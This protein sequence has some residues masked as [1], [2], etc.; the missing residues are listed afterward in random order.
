MEKD[1]PL[2]MRLFEENPYAFEGTRWLNETFPDN[3]IPPAF[4]GHNLVS[5]II[6]SVN[7]PELAQVVYT[8]LNRFH[9]KHSDTKASFSLT[10]PKAIFWQATEEDTYHAR[11]KVLSQA[12]FKS[13]LLTLIEIIK[14]VTMRHLNDTDK[15]NEVDIPQFTMQLQGRIIINIGIGRG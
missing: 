11:R 5:D 13:K 8:D 3:A 9:T 4:S 12:F 15:E 2:F 6:F 14:E 1:G 7:S 10:M